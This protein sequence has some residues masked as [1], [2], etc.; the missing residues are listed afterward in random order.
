MA[1]KSAP[2]KTKNTADAPA[3]TLDGPHDKVNQDWKWIKTTKDQWVTSVIPD[4]EICT[5]RIKS[6]DKDTF[7]C[8]RNGRY[9]G[10]EKSLTD[11]Q[12]RCA[13]GEVNLKNV[14]W[15]EWALTHP[16]EP[17]PKDEAI[18]PFLRLTE[19]ER[20]AWKH[21]VPTRPKNMGPRPGASRLDDETPEQKAAREE[22]LKKKAMKGMGGR[23]KTLRHIVT[24]MS[25]GREQ[26][27]R[28]SW[29]QPILK[30][31]GITA[32]KWS[33]DDAEGIK[34]KLEEA[35]KNGK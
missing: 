29:A 22:A 4:G 25:A 8:Y 11:A 32:T 6:L 17:P 2:S 7:C 26:R 19:E 21:H 24:E 20:K 5:A 1:R 28:R 16:D 23:M 34:A 3:P 18:P 30:E 27:V 14:F 33:P 31:L 12:R 9:L 15:G 10:S 35:M 13:G